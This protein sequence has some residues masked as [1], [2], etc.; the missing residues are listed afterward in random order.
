MCLDN[1]VSDKII[2]WCDYSDKS[3]Y[4][5]MYLMDVLSTLCD[6]TFLEKEV[7]EY[8]ADKKYNYYT[9]RDFVCSKVKEK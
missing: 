2:L 6:T 8:F 5:L 4:S 7:K 1:I 3:F 9:I